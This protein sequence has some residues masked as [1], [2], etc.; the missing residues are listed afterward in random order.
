MKYLFFFVFAI[1]FTTISQANPYRQVELGQLLFFDKV[2]SGNKNISCATCHHP[3]TG[4][5]DRLSLGIGEGGL[6]LGPART[7]GWGRD[8]VHERVPR[9]SPALFNLG[10]EDFTVMFHDGRVHIDPNHPSGF[11]SPAG[12]RLPRGL[13]SLLA[14]QAMFP[15]TSPTEMAG[16]KG[17]NSIANSA[18]EGDLMG[19]WRKLAQ[20]IQSIPEY[21]FLF[22]EAFPDVRSATDIQFK[23]IANAIAQF[24]TVAFE[25]MNSP[26][27]RYLNGDSSAMSKEQITGMKLFYGSAAC[28]RCHS[29][30]FQTDNNFH[31]LAMVP[32]GPGKGLG[33]NGLDDFGLE[34]TT[35]NP[36]D[37]YKFRTPTLRN[38]VLTGPWG[39]SGAYGTLE[40]IIK[41]HADPIRALSNYD[42]RQVML[43]YRRDLSAID[44]LLYQHNP[45]MS[46]LVRSISYR[47]VLCLKK[48][49][50]CW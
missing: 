12:D 7:T 28:V 38:V 36:K 4:S 29:G 14:A 45:S 8:A 27:D 18:V 39:H 37:R 50:D 11:H 34:M 1:F 5:T 41:H 30:T 49:S 15:V 44:F 9:N 2:L 13:N 21:V 43:P 32:V 10:H 42:H 47:P 40:G 23:H 6:G 25:A 3:L 20:R 33:W 22:V 31:S 35:N 46:D 48:R 19:V 24:E 26:F 16:Q 17:E